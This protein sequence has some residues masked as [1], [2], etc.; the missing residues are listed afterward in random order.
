MYLECIH[1]QAHKAGRRAG[2]S[3]REKHRDNKGR[4]AEL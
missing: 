3:A 1:L 2:K 4:A